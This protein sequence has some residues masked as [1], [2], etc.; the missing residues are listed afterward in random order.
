MYMKHVMKTVA[1]SLLLFAG[2]AQSQDFSVSMV[3]YKDCHTSVN[4]L[5]FSAKPQVCNMSLQAITLMIRGQ[6]IAVIDKE[7]LKFSKL[8]VGG[9]D[10]RYNRKGDEV[11]ELGSFP[12]ID[13]NGEYAIFDVE[14][15]SAPFGHVGSA[16]VDGT[17]DILTG[18]R[19]IS[20][21][22]NAIDLEKGFS[23]NVGPLTVSNQPKPVPQKSEKGGL[24]GALEKGFEKAFMGQD[25]DSLV[26]YVNGNHDALISLDVYENGKQLDQGWYTTSGE[27]RRRSY[28]KPAGS[29]IDLKLKYWDGMQRVTVPLKLN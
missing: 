4:S 28:S 26:I 9:K 27:E 24:G 11:F 22:K 23:M 20:E 5:D 14:L 3:A 2:S 7:S 12:K 18:A 15:K 1:V 21:E 13:E 6:N 19:V 25:S 16:S 29:K 10:V 17:I 8:E